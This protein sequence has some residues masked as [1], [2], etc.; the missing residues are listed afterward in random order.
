M[1]VHFYNNYLKIHTNDDL[2]LVN[3]VKL[4]YIMSAWPLKLYSKMRRTRNG[5]EISPPR[6]SPSLKA[7]DHILY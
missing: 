1:F 2:W 4:F 7:K 5:R 3:T 6:F